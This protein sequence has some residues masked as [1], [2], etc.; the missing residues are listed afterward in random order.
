MVLKGST[1]TVAASVNGTPRCLTF[2]SALLGS[3]ANSM[4]TI[5]PLFF[6]DARISISFHQVYELGAPNEERLTEP[7][8]R[9]GTAPCANSTGHQGTGCGIIPHPFAGHGEG[10]YGKLH[11]PVIDL[12]PMRRVLQEECIGEDYR[13]DG[14]T[15]QRVA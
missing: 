9:W 1:N 6:G 3:H 8:W 11:D 4:G 15:L 5:Y 12:L 10:N 7:R 14:A 13:R 2:L